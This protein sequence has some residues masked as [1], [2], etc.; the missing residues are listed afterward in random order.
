MMD[1]FIILIEVV[2][3]TKDHWWIK[4]RYLQ[5]GKAKRDKWL[6]REESFEILLLGTGEGRREGFK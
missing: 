3:K 1:T 6:N 4:N 2:E 5:K